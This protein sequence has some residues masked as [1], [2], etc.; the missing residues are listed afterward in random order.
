L[1]G[2]WKFALTGIFAGAGKTDLPEPDRSPAQRS[3]QGHLNPRLWP[4]HL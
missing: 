3:Q 4:F 2:G 1:Y